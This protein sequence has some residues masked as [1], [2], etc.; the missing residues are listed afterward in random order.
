MLTQMK[1]SMN[2]MAMYEM[3]VCHCVTDSNKYGNG[4]K[5]QFI[6]INEGSIA[7]AREGNAYEKYHAFDTQPCCICTLIVGCQC[8]WQRRGDV[9]AMCCY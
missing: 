1:E 4:S 5:V 2:V 7:W 3:V 6:T 9:Y 8:C